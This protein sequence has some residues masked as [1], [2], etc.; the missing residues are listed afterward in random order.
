MPPEYTPTSTETP[1]GK[2]LPPWAYV[3]V[4]GGGVILLVWYKDKK[5]KEEESKG[6]NS[7][8]YIPVS[9]E[10]VAG[11][12]APGLSGTIQGEEASFLLNASEKQNE[13][14]QEE[15]R[16]ERT[17][18][19]ELVSELISD[20]RSQTGGGAPSEGQN[21]L[22]SEL[23]NVEKIKE[24]FGTSSGTGAGS[25]SSGS[26]SANNTSGNGSGGGGSGATKTASPASPTCPSSYPYSGS[27]G[28]YKVIKCGNG[29][30]GHEY[31]DTGHTTECQ[32]KT[33]GPVNSGH[34]KGLYC[35][36]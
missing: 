19:N 14:V 6:Y 23:T 12:A 3:A 26:A 30:E 8:S 1:K 25:T 13:R 35:N 31:S 36:W 18:N 16:G 4:I 29:C 27:H 10:N 9:A 33:S 24:L 17:R 5:K 20:I 7:G 32:H 15:L 21:T 28:C 2:K 22:S 11:V 34:P